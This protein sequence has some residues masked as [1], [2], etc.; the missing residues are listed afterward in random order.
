MAIRDTTRVTEILLHTD[1]RQEEREISEYSPVNECDKNQRAGEPRR[2]REN[3][4]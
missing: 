1:K 2:G 4:T 3:E